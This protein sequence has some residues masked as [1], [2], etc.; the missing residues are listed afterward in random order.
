LR[1]GERNVKCKVR[2]PCA[3]HHGKYGSR[4]IAPVIHYLGQAALAPGMSSGTHCTESWVGR[5]SGL[6]GFGE[7][8]TSPTGIRT[9]DRPAISIHHTNH[10]TCRTSRYKYK[11]SGC[12]AV[13][14]QMMVVM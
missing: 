2:L 8:K 13:V 14:V 3:R 9:P 4:C 10:I 7:L 12:S 1:H 5:R 11:L 6:E